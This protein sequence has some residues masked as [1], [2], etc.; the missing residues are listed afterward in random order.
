MFKKVR[1][2]GGGLYFLASLGTSCLRSASEASTSCYRSQK[3]NEPSPQKDC[4]EVQQGRIV[5][6]VDA[7][8]AGASM[9]LSDLH[10]AGAVSVFG[11]HWHEQFSLKGNC[12][13]DDSSKHAHLIEAIVSKR[14][15]LVKV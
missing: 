15:F 6:S 12:V 11:K 5:A 3:R 9:V 2:E 13:R 1:S 14:E 8:R 7:P 10:E 4:G